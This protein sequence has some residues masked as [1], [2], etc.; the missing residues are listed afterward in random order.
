MCGCPADRA[1][2]CVVCSRRVIVASSPPRAVVAAIL[3]AV[4]FLLI[5]VA[6]WWLAKAL[7]G[8]RQPRGARAHAAARPN[9]SAGASQTVHEPPGPPPTTTAPASRP[10]GRPQPPSVSCQST[11]G[12]VQQIRTK[13][14]RAGELRRPFPPFSHQDLYIVRQTTADYLPPD[15]D[16][17][18]AVRR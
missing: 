14:R 15:V 1:R 17:Y 9:L 8:P 5:V 6:V 18:L 2:G 3:H 16:A 11:S 4:P 10:A 12:Q 13:G 7:R